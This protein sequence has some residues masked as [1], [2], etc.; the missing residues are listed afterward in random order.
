MPCR[1]I[2]LLS[3]VT[4]GSTVAFVEAGGTIK[5]LLELVELDVVVP[6]LVGCG[7]NA[8]ELGISTEERTS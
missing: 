4:A 6:S 8:G 1:N 2:N 3:L 5:I 7:L